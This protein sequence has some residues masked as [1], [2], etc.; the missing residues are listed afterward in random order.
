MKKHAVADPGHIS[1]TPAWKPVSLGWT[2]FA[3]VAVIL[4]LVL[5][6]GVALWWPR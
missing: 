3:I 1:H 4:A 5:L 6:A 2:E